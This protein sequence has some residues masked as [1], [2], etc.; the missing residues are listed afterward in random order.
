MVCHVHHGGFL[1]AEDEVAKASAK[2][3]TQAQPDVVGHKNQH[4]EVANHHLNHM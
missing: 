3:N 4:Q 2:Y 1:P